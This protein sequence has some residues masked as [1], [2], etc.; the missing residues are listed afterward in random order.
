MGATKR[1]SF[2]IDHLQAPRREFHQ[3]QILRTKK[4]PGHYPS[5]LG[6]VGRGELNC[7]LK[8]AF[9]LD[10]SPRRLKSI[11]ESALF[12]EW[13]YLVYIGLGWTKS[14]S[15][16]APSDPGSLP[17]TG[18]ALQSGRYDALRFRL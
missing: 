13:L 6:L 5:P 18:Q 2:C 7:C 1:R 16:L 15:L 9:I 8:A 14:T 4:G 12:I 3:S 11:P 10:S 17:G